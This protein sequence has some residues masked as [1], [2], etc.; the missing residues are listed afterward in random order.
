MTP[1]IQ[2][3]TSR[4]FSLCLTALVAACGGASN[5]P[6]PVTPGL[7][8][9]II[10]PAP[11]AIVPLTP[12][13]LRQRAKAANSYAIYYGGLDDAKI[14]A[15]QT[16]PL[17]IVH[18]SNGNITRTQIQ[19]IQNGANSTAVLC[20][21]SIGEDSRTYNLSDAQMRADPRFVGDATGPSIDPRGMGSSVRSLMGLNPLGTPTQGGFASWYLN[22]NA[23]YNASAPKNVPDQNPNFLT[24]FV[25]AG[26]PK[27]FDVV[28]NDL[29]DSAVPAGYPPNP[30]GLKE[31]LTS[32]Y[33]RGLG[34]DGVFL[35]TIDTAAP[36]FYHPSGSNFEWTAHGFTQFIERLRNA[37]PDKLV[38]QNRG[39]FFFD[40]RLPHYEASARASIDHVLFESYR[41]NSN[42]APLFDPYFFPDNKY[43]YAP[44]IM[45]E[46][47][48]GEGFK[49]LSL[50][51]ADG[52]AGPKAGI[53]IATLNAQSNLGLGELLTDMQEAMM[54]GFR[55][56]LTDRT[57][58][59]I[60]NFV[61]THANLADTSPPQWSS[62]FNANAGLW[63][64][65]PAAQTPRIGIQRA[66]AAA[67]SVTLSWDVALDLNRVGYALYY[68]TTPFDFVGDPSL[69]SAT[70]LVLSPSVGTGYDK[71]WSSTH[72]GQALQTVYPYEQ[73]LSNLAPRNTYYFV[74]RA[75]DSAG[76]EEANN[77][78]VSAVL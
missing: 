53:D 56:Y 30:L 18:P 67:G 37:Y 25:N 24:R 66:S 33:G 15:L 19:A 69:S 31:M 58:V 29:A 73:K 68:K 54:V 11:A 57:I 6:S 62:I 1:K 65:P 59:L 7:I 28:N 20:Y 13:T 44:K 55:H 4:Y 47:N 75:F 61:Q 48:R 38:L 70:R 10:S 9:S 39:L 49:V 17:V 60:N 46:A 51:Y 36:N 76:N 26:D 5:T 2:A 27:W 78:A 77:I 71:V 63:P 16:Y 32:S 40:P 42:T 3:F 21:I 74:I 8:G 43:N 52:W 34:C 22:D 23:T 50:G 35:D 45:A 41:L 12:L 72:P 64:T 14:Q